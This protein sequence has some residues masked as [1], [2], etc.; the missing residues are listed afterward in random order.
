MTQKK[1]VISLTLCALRRGIASYTVKNQKTKRQ[2]MM[3]SVYR[4]DDNEDH[5]LLKIDVP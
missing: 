4:R 2:Q 3:E 5:I 1:D